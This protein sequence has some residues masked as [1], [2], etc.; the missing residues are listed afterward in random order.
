MS[1]TGG[2]GCLHNIKGFENDTCSKKI[3]LQ[4]ID[5]FENSVV[6]RGQVGVAN[7]ISR[8]ADET[9]GFQ[10]LFHALK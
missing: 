9:S 8:T 3:V 2:P 7:W 1:S 4:R 10:L 5:E 6:E